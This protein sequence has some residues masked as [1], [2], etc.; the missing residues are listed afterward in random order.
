[1]E[2]RELQ[3]LLWWLHSKESAC[4]VGDLGSRLRFDPWVRM[5][6]WRRK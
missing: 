6:L 2:Y 5:I 4:S 3:G 1:M